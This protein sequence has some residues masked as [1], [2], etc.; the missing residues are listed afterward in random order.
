[1]MVLGSAGAIQVLCQNCKLFIVNALL[2]YCSLAGLS[3]LDISRFS[4]EIVHCEMNAYLFVWNPNKWRWATLEQQIDELQNS[5]T[6]AELWSCSS[7]R[8]IKKGD[9]AFLARV[10]MAPRGIFGAG[11]IDSDPFLS[12]HWNGEGRNIF[13]VKIEFEVLLNPNEVP[14][15]STD[16][17]N[18]GSLAKQQ[19]TP[20]SS[21]I[22]IK[23]ELTD[24]LEA[25]WFDFLTTQEINFSPFAPVENNVQRDFT[26][27]AATQVTLTRYE[28]N[29]YAR[30]MCL[31]RHGYQC[32]VCDFDF[33]AYYGPIG[34]DFIHVHHL[35]PIAAVKKVYSV[36]PVE[37][38]R[39][40][41]PNCHAMIHRRVPAFGI[42][43]LKAIIKK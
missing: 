31:E 14:I 4:E 30:K 19:W 34:K 40:V 24:D 33:A 25:L 5:G 36:D 7:H 8:T 13:R 29:P 28:R 22:S 21:G 42:E 6:T 39:P 17:L 35:T 11:Y 20:Q 9:R 23:R 15:L 10:G 1:M 2:E 37:D 38:L 32:S 12:P 27:G 18:T 43:E 26:E 3:A 41:C 16:I